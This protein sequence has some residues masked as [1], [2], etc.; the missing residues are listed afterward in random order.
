VGLTCGD[1]V[2]A[3]ID[4]GDKSFARQRETLTMGRMGFY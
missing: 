2:D 3:I 1:L 4:Q